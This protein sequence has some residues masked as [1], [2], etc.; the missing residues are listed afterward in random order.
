MT[1][2]V[3]LV[4][5]ALT[6]ACSKSRPVDQGTGSSKPAPTGSAVAVADAADGS[7]T[8]SAAGSATGSAAGSATGSGDQGSAGS[9]DQGSAAGSAAMGSGAAGEESEFDKLSHDDKV[10][11]MKTKVMPVMKPVF[12]KFDP[13]EYANFGCK[14]C[15]GKDP[16]KSKYKMP[17]PDLK[18]LDFAAIKAGKEEPKMV[19]FMSKQ[20]KPQ[21]AKIFG[22]PEMSATEP[23][24][25]G[26][27][28]C[29]TQKK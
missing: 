23:N 28:D 29:H 9:A 21:M 24:G 4:A 8:G 14:T 17:N 16:Q 18:P 6:A 11:F 13:K 25:F 22:E 10:K 12:Q 20:V 26:C 27:L 19:E 7:A 15:H 2:L 3:C 5:F 1:K